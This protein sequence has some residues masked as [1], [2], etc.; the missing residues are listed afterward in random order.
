MII[1]TTRV[2]HIHHPTSST[3]LPPPL[4]LHAILPLQT[5]QRNL[6]VLY[7]TT[8]EMVFRS[9]PLDFLYACFCATLVCFCHRQLNQL[10][11]SIFLGA[12]FDAEAIIKPTYRRHY[13]FDYIEHSNEDLQP[14]SSIRSIHQL[15]GS[16]II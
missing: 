11:S 7:P 10:Y 1:S 14:Q 6:S 9:R 2:H 15:S 12:S 4:L 8:T 3:N 16:L 13:H 5:S